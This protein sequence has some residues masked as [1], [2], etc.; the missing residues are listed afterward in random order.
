MTAL[1]E[2]TPQDDWTDDTLHTGTKAPLYPPSIAQ[3]VQSYRRF[4]FCH[5]EIADG[6][7]LISLM[8]VHP[9]LEKQLSWLEIDVIHSSELQAK[10][11]HGLE[12]LTVCN[13]TLE[14]VLQKYKLAAIQCNYQSLMMNVTMSLWA[15]Y[16]PKCLDPP[17]PIQFLEFILSDIVD[18]KDLILV[19]LSNMLLEKKFISQV[20]NEIKVECEQFF[21]LVQQRR[22]DSALAV[23]KCRVYME[24]SHSQAVMKEVDFEM[25]QFWLW[26]NMLALAGIGTI[27]GVTVHCPADGRSL[28]IPASDNK[29]LDLLHLVIRFSG[30]HCHVDRATKVEDQ[31]EG[32]DNK[33]QSSQRRKQSD[34][35]KANNNERSEATEIDGEKE[36]EDLFDLTED[37]EVV[38]QTKLTK[39]GL[40]RDNCDKTILVANLVD[41]VDAVALPTPD[42]KA[43]CF[44]NETVL[45]EMIDLFDPTLKGVSVSTCQNQLELW[46]QSEEDDEIECITRKQRDALEI[47]FD[48]INMITIS[49]EDSEAPLNY[50]QDKLRRHSESCRLS[51]VYLLLMVVS[52]HAERTIIVLSSRGEML[53]TVK[54]LGED[55]EDGE[56]RYII[57]SEDGRHFD[58]TSRQ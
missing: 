7:R 2:D 36:Q 48:F 58:A 38:L 8:H 25:V 14:S 34:E 49:E 16:A 40:Q 39:M 51:W 18:H 53:K 57:Q 3:G 37:D 5:P 32:K 28:E 26:M 50:L 31:E 1:I 24:T 21:D 44:T 41:A 22:W 9:M 33:Q 4:C 56:I 47:Y 55:G 52:L 15:S 12:L 17:S 10:F 20:T 46:D 13:S 54:Y 11:D 27:R 23:I 19:E 42:F 35:S 29:D 43:F 45:K 6:L 30:S